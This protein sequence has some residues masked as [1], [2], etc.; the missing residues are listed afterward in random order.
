MTDPITGDFI[1]DPITGKNIEKDQTH[2][3]EDQKMIFGFLYWLQVDEDGM[4]KRHVKILLEK[5]QNPT[6]ESIEQ[7]MRDLKP[8][9]HLLKE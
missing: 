1:I 9:T 6:L 3:E 2:Y 8:I 5:L 4:V 7:E